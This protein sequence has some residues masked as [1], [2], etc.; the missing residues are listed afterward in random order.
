MSG[1]TEAEAVE[2]ICPMAMANSKT[3]ISDHCLGARCMAWRWTEGKIEI[4]YG[5]V[6]YDANGRPDD[7]GM[8]KGAGWNLVDCG[9]DDNGCSQ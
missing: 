5:V 8:P 3:G 1:I 7:P 9:P 2:R 6:Q 4:G